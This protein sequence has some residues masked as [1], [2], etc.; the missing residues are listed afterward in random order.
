MALGFQI[1]ARGFRIPNSGSRIPSRNFRIFRSH[2]FHRNGSWIPS[3]FVDSGFHKTGF[4]IPKA[5]I[6]WIPDSFISGD[7]Y[8][9]GGMKGQVVSQICF[10]ISSSLFEYRV[11]KTLVSS[12]IT[13]VS[14]QSNSPCSPVL[15][16]TSP[17]GK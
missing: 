4:Q 11:Q 8:R 10:P 1:P 17:F 7:H 9:W 12:S 14:T 6:C 3:K 5:H 13:L 16:L 15:R 2:W